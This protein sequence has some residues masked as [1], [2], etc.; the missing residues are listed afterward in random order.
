MTTPIPDGMHSVTPALTLKNC[1][2]AL[3]FYK[4]AFG[5]L[6]IDRAADP[7]GQKVWHAAF[8]IGDSTIFC[9]DEFPE[10]GSTARP[11]SLWIYGPDIDARFQRAVDAGAKVAM[12]PTDAFWGDRFA[13]VT[14]PFGNDWTLAQ[15]MK[16]LTPAELKAAADAEIARMSKKS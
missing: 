10:M 7:S 16:S 4:K 9:N 14:D 3:E 11:A 12:P 15:R 1:A 6:E 2:E 13:K 5:A 8:K